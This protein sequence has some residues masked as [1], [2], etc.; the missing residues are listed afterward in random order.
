MVILAYEAKPDTDLPPAMFSMPVD[1]A[2]AQ[3][4]K[5][6]D[7]SRQATAFVPTTNWH[8]FKATTRVLFLHMAGQLSMARAGGSSGKPNIPRQL[9]ARPQ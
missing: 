7:T 4:A 5:R 2:S 3:P 1:I 8:V 9:V 6:L